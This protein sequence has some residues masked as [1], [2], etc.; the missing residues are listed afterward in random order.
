MGKT[1]GMT[2]PSVVYDFDPRNIPEEI[3]KAVGLLV[4][5]SAHT[6]M[7]VQTFIG[8]VLQI[9][10]IE[11]LALTS[12]MSGQLRD[13][14][15]RALIELNATNVEV[16]DEIDGLLDAIKDADAARNRVAH[17][18][19][20][21]HPDTNDV[22]FWKESARGTLRLALEPVDAKQLMTQAEAL[23]QAGLALMRFMVLFQLH[24][25]P[26]TRPF[27]EALNRSPTARKARRMKTV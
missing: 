18:P 2:Q 8:A 10:E 13:Q 19:L 25:G 22:Y 14:V 5:A 26:R 12:Q 4:V 11:T 9:D 15:A 23:Y 6:E 20:A 24:P 27:R 7:I 21:R 1:A 17:C 16:V 3:S